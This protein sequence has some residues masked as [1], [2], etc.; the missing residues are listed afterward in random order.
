MIL[1]FRRWLGEMK[2]LNLRSLRKNFSM[3]VSRLVINHTFFQVLS[4]FS[5]LCNKSCKSKRFFDLLL[6]TTS[7][8]EIKMKSKYLLD[9]CTSLRYRSIIS[10]TWCITYFLKYVYNTSKKK[11]SKIDYLNNFSILFVRYRF[12]RGKI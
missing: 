8:S 2:S 1:Y 6:R 7:C 12:L 9:L 11:N 5:W 10:I 3:F 4:S